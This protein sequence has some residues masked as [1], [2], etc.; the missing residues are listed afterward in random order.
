[1][2]RWVILLTV[3]LM[4]FGSV[5]A[6]V[7]QIG[8][9]AGINCADIAVDEL[10][11][12]GDDLKQK[13]NSGPW[14][15]GYHLG[16]YARFELPG[17]YLQPE[18]LLTKLNTEVIID[19]FESGLPINNSDDARI[20]YV[21]LDFPVMIGFKLGPARL[22]AGP[23]ASRVITNE[24]EG[25]NIS[26]QSGTFWGYQAGVGFDIW[27]VLIDLKYEGGFNFQTDQVIF[28]GRQ[29]NMDSRTRQLILSLGY[30]F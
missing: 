17:L 28:A 20:S 16:V 3:A 27:K 13:L 26:F 14:D 8:A 10:F 21:R 22:N 15:Y 5:Q 6:Q 4:A 11:D 12:L 2:R 18:V 23:V 1:M 9:R 25:I 30:R 19:E 7:F 29:F 24:T